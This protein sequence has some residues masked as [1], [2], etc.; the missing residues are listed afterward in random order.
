[1]AA[2]GAVVVL[3]GVV[4][5]ARTLGGSSTIA[6]KGARARYADRTTTGT[7]RPLS[8]AQRQAA[9]EAA[10]VQAARRR[11]PHVAVAGR[12]RREMALTFDDGPGPYTPQVVR[13]LQRR[14]VPATF[15]QVGQSAKRFT[16]GGQDD[17]RDR[18]LVVGNHTETHAHLPALPVSAQISEVDDASAVIKGEGNPPPRLFRPPYGAFDRSTLHVLANRRMLMVLWTIDSQDYQRPGVATIVRR[19]VDGAR[20]GAIVLMHDAGGDRSQTVAALPA[21]IHQLRERHYK[22]VTIPRLMLDDPPP[23]KQPPVA[24]GVG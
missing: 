5:A 14:H 13:V 1:V 18:N 15:F 24:V 7:R 12:E 19:V 20:P 17:R 6:A 10:A 4:L 23:R 16:R 3:V 2:A 8:A 22:L 11:T 9:R 21:I